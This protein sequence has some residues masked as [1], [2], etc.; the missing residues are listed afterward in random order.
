MVRPSRIV[1]GR[2]AG[3]LAGPALFA[4]GHTDDAQRVAALLADRIAALAAPGSDAARAAAECLAPRTAWRRRIALLEGAL[5]DVAEAR[6]DVEFVVWDVDALAAVEREAFDVERSSLM[7]RDLF[8]VIERVAPGGGWTLVRTATDGGALLDELDVPREFGDA[9]GEAGDGPGAWFSPDVRPLIAWLLARERMS[10][11]E[12]DEIRHTVAD[13][14]GHLVD[15]VYQEAPAAIQDAAK[16]VSALRAPQHVNG[17]YGR[18]RFAEQGGVSATAI[19]TAARAALQAC[20]LVQPTAAPGQWWMPR[21]VRARLAG[22]AEGTMPAEVAALHVAEG[23]AATPTSSVSEVVEAHHHAVRSGDLDLAVT[24][25]RYYGSEL[26]EVAKQIS[27][28]AAGPPA[29]KQGFARAAQIYQ[30]ILDRFDATDAYA[31]EYYAYNLARADGPSDEVLRAY[32]RAHAHRPR[33]PLYHGRW[34]GYRGQ[35]GEVVVAEAIAGIREYALERDQSRQPVSF[36]ARAVFAGLDRGDA[37]GQ[38]TAI[39][40]ACGALL[41]DLAPNA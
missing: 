5:A 10:A 15:L 30:T 17:G 7:R 9:V 33:N 24:T 31:W 22:L 16:L 25:A 12:L 29:S 23:R 4:F 18:L 36:F 13:P 20:G 41:R 38:V 40:A 19:P 14:A 35:L 3:P 11:G 1:V 39:R 32:Q 2:P 6:P 21:T 26:A 28:D 27:R 8:G 34:L 37:H